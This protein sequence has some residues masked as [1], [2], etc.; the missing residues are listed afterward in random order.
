MRYEILPLLVFTILS[1]LAIIIAFGSFSITLAG[2]DVSLWIYFMVTV[3]VVKS[4]EISSS[5]Y[6]SRVF[7]DDE[8]TCETKIKNM[9]KYLISKVEVQDFSSDGYIAS[10]SREISGSILP[11][12]AMSLSYVMKFRTRGEHYFYGINIHVE[13]T[14]KLFSIERK[15]EVK[16]KILVF[17]KILPIDELRTTLIDP[18]SG[19]KTDFKILEDSSHIV[20]IRE[21]S[22]EPFQRIHWKASAHTGD[23]MVKEYEYTGSSKIRMYVDYNLPKEIYARNVWA[24]MRKDY[25]EYASMASSG[26]I[27]YLYDKDM[28]I[29]L[30]VLGDK[31]YTVDQQAKDYIPYFDALA[32][33]KGTDDPSDDLLLQTQIM[34]DLFSM[35]R[36][37]T[38]IIISMYLTDDAIP[39]LLT[40]KSRVARLMVFVIP[41][42]FRMPYDKKYDTYAILPREVQRLR[43]QS[44]ILVE[45]NVM[46][47]VMMDNESFDEVIK[48]YDKTMEIF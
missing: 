8:V 3:R 7:T 25:E 18:V 11:N 37:T 6:P 15:I 10:G 48:R 46:V 13:S 43:D 40:V 36:T 21:Y 31:I 28:P 4:L 32:I 22:G 30:K 45:N 20:G 9:S 23:L 39:K 19:K 34:G 17:P 35:S 44:A 47:H 2:I 33:A 38:V 41:Y 42:G 14:L 16:R 26:I 12:R 24:H 29:T 1:I 27:K 5:V